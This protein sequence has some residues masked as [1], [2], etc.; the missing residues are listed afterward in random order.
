MIHWLLK[1]TICR[2]GLHE[3]SMH[4][5]SWPDNRTEVW[6]HCVHCQKIIEKVMLV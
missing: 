1:M 2:L 3:A 5:L 4:E 6:F